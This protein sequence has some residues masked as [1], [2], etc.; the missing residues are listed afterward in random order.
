MTHRIVHLVFGPVQRALRH[1]ALTGSMYAIHQLLFSRKSYLRQM[2]WWRSFRA[3][4]PIGVRGEPIPWLSYPAIEFLAARAQPDWHVFEYGAGNSTLWWASRVDSVVSCEHDAEWAAFIEANRPDNVTL[5][6]EPAEDDAYV[7]SLGSYPQ[8]FDV[9]VLD[10]IRRSECVP[11]L[12][13]GLK[14]S[15]VIVFDNTDRPRNKPAAKKLEDIGFKR[16]D[17]V[18][19]VPGSVHMD[20][21]S[22]FYRPDNCIGL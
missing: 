9:V 8:R 7:A 14:P 22:V 6:V 19:P 4:S 21:T 15:G 17:F 16:I 20:A 3:K 10:G 13:Q 11:Y 2:G 1:N 12:E 18:G 5:L